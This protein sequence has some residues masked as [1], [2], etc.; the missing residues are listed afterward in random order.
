MAGC[1]G[2]GQQ[3]VENLRNEPWWR[4]AFTRA[5]FLLVTAEA[6]PLGPAES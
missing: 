3:S 2:R 4:E 1:S 5:L 6:R